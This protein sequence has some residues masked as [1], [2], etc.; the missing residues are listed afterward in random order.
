MQEKK[1]RKKMA[2]SGPVIIRRNRSRR[3]TVDL[4]GSIVP[5]TPRLDELKF[6]IGA[7]GSPRFV[8]GEGV[9]CGWRMDVSMTGCQLAWTGLDVRRG[10]MDELGTAFGVVG[11]CHPPS[12]AVAVQRYI[13]AEDLQSWS[14]TTIVLGPLQQQL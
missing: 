10:W 14:Y 9:D 2:K 12:V 13:G 1:K 5:V 6:Q 4:R 7:P 8:P 3:A 11:C